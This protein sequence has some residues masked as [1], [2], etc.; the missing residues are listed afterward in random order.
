MFART[1]EKWA[2]MKVSLLRMRF[3]FFEVLLWNLG[4]YPRQK[5]QGRV[6]APALCAWI[7]GGANVFVPPGFPKL[8]EKRTHLYEWSHCPLFNPI[9]EGQE[10]WAIFLYFQKQLC[11]LYS[12][13][14]KD[15]QLKNIEHELG[16]RCV[17]RNNVARLTC[18]K[19]NLRS[20]IIIKLRLWKAGRYFT[21]DMQVNVLNV[22]RGS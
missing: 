21:C 19:W 16:S 13:K 2:E 18:L 6:P 22:K 3:L 4:K 9:R 11:N 12:G 7:K 14:F 5:F 20:N 1:K 8:L 17:M 10:E 15:I